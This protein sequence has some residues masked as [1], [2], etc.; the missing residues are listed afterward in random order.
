MMDV[1]LQV[2]IVDHQQRP[3]ANYPS[4]Q[5]TITQY[6]YNYTNGSTKVVLGT[7]QA[8][9]GADGTV[10]AEIPTDPLQTYFYLSVSIAIGHRLV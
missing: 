7:Y 3:L 1:C 2:Q 6:I 8:S 10:I 5:A 4:K 9:V